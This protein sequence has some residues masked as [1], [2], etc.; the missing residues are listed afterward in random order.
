MIQK[1]MKL[2]DLGVNVTCVS[3]VTRKY[4][5][6]ILELKNDQNIPVVIG[7]SPT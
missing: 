4:L 6:K 7:F 5:A 3:V 2:F 1:H